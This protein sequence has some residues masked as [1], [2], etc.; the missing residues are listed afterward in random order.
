MILKITPQRDNQ[1]LPCRT[2]KPSTTSKSLILSHNLSI[3][4]V[5]RSEIKPGTRACWPQSLVYAQTDFKITLNHVLPCSVTAQLVSSECP[6]TGSKLP[7]K[8]A[9]FLPAANAHALPFCSCRGRCS[10]PAWRTTLF[11]CRGAVPH[12]YFDL[13]NFEAEAICLWCWGYLKPS[14]IQLICETYVFLPMSCRC[15]FNWVC[16]IF[17]KVQWYTKQLTCWPIFYILK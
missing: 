5:F 6:N 7:R 9:N 15:R 1:G 3:I 2:K 16:Q 4:T 17:R 11:T 10:F 13:I 12:I 14:K 8:D